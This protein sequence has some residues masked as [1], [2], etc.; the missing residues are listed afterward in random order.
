M[1]GVVAG[2]GGERELHVQAGS[3]LVWAVENDS[4]AERLHAVLQA[5]QAGAAGEV[6]ATDAVVADPEAEDGVDGF[7]PLLAYLDRPDVAGGEAL[8][9]ILRPGKAGS[10]TAA[11]HTRIL[12]MALSRAQPTPGRAQV[13]LSRRR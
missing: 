12:T 3:R 13:I 2:W 4:A 10:N 7:H 6:G 5:E 8:A 11:D 1:G 9:G